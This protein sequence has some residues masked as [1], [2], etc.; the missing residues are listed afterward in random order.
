MKIYFITF[1]MNVNQLMFVKNKD[2]LVHKNTQ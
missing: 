1:V 2:F